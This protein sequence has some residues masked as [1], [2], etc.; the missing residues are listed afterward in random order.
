MKIVYFTN[1]EFEWV[2]VINHGPVLFLHKALNLVPDEQETIMNACKNDPF[3]MHYFSDWFEH[4]SIQKKINSGMSLFFLGM[5]IPCISQLNIYQASD[6][7]PTYLLNIYLSL[8]NVNI[9]KLPGIAFEGSFFKARHINKEIILKLKKK[10]NCMSVMD[11]IVEVWTLQQTF[12]NKR[13]SIDCVKN[14]FVIIF[15]DTQQQ[16]QQAYAYLL[17]MGWGGVIFS[18]EPL[19]TQNNHN[20]TLIHT[21]VRSIRMVFN[22]ISNLTEHANNVTV[23]FY[24][25]LELQHW[26]ENS[27][28]ADIV[29]RQFDGENIR[30]FEGVLNAL[31]QTLNIPSQMFD[32]SRLV[33]F[34][35]NTLDLNG[36]DCESMCASLMQ[37]YSGSIVNL[38]IDQTLG[39]IQF[40]IHL[41]C[42]LIYNS[43]FELMI[44][45]QIL[46]NFSIEVFESISDLVLIQE[47][48]SSNELAQSMLKEFILGFGRQS[49]NIANYEQIEL[50]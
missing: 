20:I 41:V 25:H 18:L 12:L 32:F 46:S 1:T 7:P 5:Y 50:G 6:Y 40:S 33:G 28:E 48:S 17:E 8:P 36:S 2:N 24:W 16:A 31:K 23:L 29:Y 13:P 39:D 38:N 3:I 34:R 43:L 42:S 26:L 11:Q 35:L 4:A 27:Q 45:K 30:L 44:V 14:E 22:V 15:C 37:L 10:H 49:S 9:L 21:A 47:S 19:Q